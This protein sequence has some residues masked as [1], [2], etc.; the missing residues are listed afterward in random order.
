MG[1]GAEAVSRAQQKIRLVMALRNQGIKDTRVLA[2]I[3]RVPREMFVPAD[4]AAKAY[5]DQALPIGCGQAISQPF[6][7]AFMTEKLALDDRCKVLE[8]GTGSGYQAA[9]LAA[10]SR[11]VYTLERHAALLRQAQ[12]RFTRLRLT[13]ITA[14]T[15]DGFRGWPQQAAFDRIVVTAAATDVP[16][17][18]VSQLKPGGIMIV[19]IGDA[20]GPQDL[21]RI[22]RLDEGYR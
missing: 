1:P 5:D 18:L 15:G 14:M 2:A 8:I 12:E 22:T 16:E 11:R 17:V 21:W 19:P 9:I 13:N 7:V 3:E 4:S 20:D 10:L 6:V